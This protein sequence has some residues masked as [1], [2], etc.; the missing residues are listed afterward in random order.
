MAIVLNWGLR[1]LPRRLGAKVA[2]GVLPFLPQGG[3]SAAPVP[4]T[5]MILIYRLRNAGYVEQLVRQ[6]QCAN[7]R[8][9]LWGL[10]GVAPS[11]AQLTVGAGPG[12]RSHLLT[13]LVEQARLAPSDYLLVCDDDAVFAVG[14][15]R[16]FLQ[17]AVKAQFM[18]SQPAHTLDSHY[19]FA[20]TCGR[21][22]L[23]ARTTH[24]VEIGPV[25]LIHPAFRT[26]V[27]PMRDDLGMGWG[28]EVEWHSALS[29][30][31]FFGIVDAVLI[32]HCSP[33]GVDYNTEVEARRLAQFL[34]A[35]GYKTSEDMCKTIG[36]WYRWGRFDRGALCGA[37]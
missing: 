25:V 16:D 17:I 33:A 4:D 30:G 22:H 21:P 34:L 8:V 15:L 12:T 19:N 1:K 31:E 13:K 37:G 24:F 20:F 29:A 7:T 23:I 2:A 32:R 14:G 3:D 6:A 27:F 11:L 5:V 28:A 35:A 26:R 18:V 9:L 36:R 10:D